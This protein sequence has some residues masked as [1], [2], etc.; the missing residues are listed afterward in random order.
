MMALNGTKY[1]L[2]KENNAIY[3]D[4]MS[5][6][7][8]KSGDI[9]TIQH[10]EYDALSLKI[11]VAGNDVSVKPADQDEEPGDEYT[12]HVRLVGYFESALVNQKGYDA[13]SGTYG[14]L[15]YAIPE[16]T[17]TTQTLI[18]PSGCNLTLVNM[19]ILSSVRIVVQ[20]GGTLILRDSTVQGIVDVQNGGTFSMNY[21]DYTDGGTFLTGASINGQLVLRDGATLKNAKIYSNTNNIANGTEARKNTNPVVVT[22][23]NVNIEG[24]VFIRGDEAPTGTDSATGKSYAGQTGLMVKNEL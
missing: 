20:D 17:E 6:V 1:Y 21:D 9:L 10:P 22:E 4:K 19:D 24:Q 18:I 11:V 14:E 16:G 12:L 2:D 8:F 7:P 23:G 15:G 13:T 5:G 3:F